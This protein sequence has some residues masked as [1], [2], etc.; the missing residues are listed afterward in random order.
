MK[1]YY[2]SGS[3]I[4]IYSLFGFLAFAITSCGS[5]QNS[6]YYDGDGIYGG[7]ENSQ[8]QTTP[9]NKSQSSKY[10]EYFSNLNRDAE[11]FTNV[12]NYSTVTNDTVKK[13]ESYNANNS[14]WGS[15]PQSITVNVYDNSWG[16]SYWNNYW[17]GSYW[18]WNSWYGPYWGWGWNNWYGPSWSLGIGWNSWYGPWYGGYYGYGYNNW[19]NNYYNHYYYSYAGGRR[20]TTYYGSRNANGRNYTNYTR[21][22]RDNSPILNG[23]R[24]QNFGGRNQSFGTPRTNTTNPVRNNSYSTPP[25]I[26]TNQN[27][28]APTR[29]NVRP[30]E[31]T[32]T[33]S[34]TPSTNYGGGRSNYGGSGGGGG[35]SGGRSSSGGRR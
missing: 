19:C 16:W 29:S 11:I 17:Y 5:Y 7:S 9:D 35:F 13:T 21:G 26:N 1:T 6:S 33:R 15:N 4:S 32:P 12:D 10:Q 34:Y 28:T 23:T 14:S 31:S 3:R 2:L 8:K 18:G 30:Q 22:Y 20:G 27:N 24:G 25:R